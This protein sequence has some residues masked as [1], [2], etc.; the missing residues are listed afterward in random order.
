MSAE[1]GPLERRGSIARWLV[2]IYRTLLVRRG[3]RWV[4]VQG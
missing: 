1:G 4:K 3:D 2:A